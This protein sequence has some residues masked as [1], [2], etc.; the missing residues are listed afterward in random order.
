MEQR[1][2]CW[3]CSDLLGRAQVAKLIVI[4]PSVMEPGR[5]QAVLQVLCVRG[6]GC[7]LKRLSEGGTSAL[8]LTAN[9]LIYYQLADFRDALTR[10]Y[11][12]VPKIQCLV[13][14]QVRLVFYILLSLWKRWFYSPDSFVSTGVSG[15]V[16]FCMF[17][18]YICV[19]ASV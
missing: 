4:Y 17:S 18:M 3:G 11:G 2:N 15:T 1:T 6:R 7:S 16:T 19:Q 14:E 10:I 9:A 12:V 5:P 8:K 13:P